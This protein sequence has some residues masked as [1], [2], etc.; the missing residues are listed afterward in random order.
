MEYINTDINL[1]LGFYN[2]WLILVI[3]AFFAWLLMKIGDKMRG[4]KIENVEDHRNIKIMIVSSLPILIFLLA[5]VFVPII[6]GF[7]F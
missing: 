2:L 6:T 1:E 7:L 3:V 4:E 5:V